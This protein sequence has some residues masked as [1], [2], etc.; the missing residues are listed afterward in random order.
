MK[1]RVYAASDLS[2][3]DCCRP[4]VPLWRVVPTRDEEGHSLTDFMM[5][6]PHLREKPSREIEQ[7][8]EN[9]R[10]VLA[11]HREVVFADLNLP[12]NILWVSLRPR[13]GAIAEIA[14][15]I[16]VFVPAAVLVAHYSQPH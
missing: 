14:S 10:S 9:I 2:M 5:L 7:T 15:A 16:R 3:T 6:I 1:I 8:S 4:G 11:L 13:L 12:L